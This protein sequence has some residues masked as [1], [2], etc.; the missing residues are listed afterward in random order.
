MQQGLCP[1]WLPRPSLQA[2][3]LTSRAAAVT[4]HEIALLSSPWTSS[5]SE[6]LHILFTHLKVCLW[7]RTQT[8]A[9]THTPLPPLL[10]C[11][12]CCPLPKASYTSMWIREQPGKG[13]PN[14]RDHI[15]LSPRQCSSNTNRARCYFVD[16]PEGILSLS[17]AWEHPQSCWEWGPWNGMF[18]VLVVHLYRNNSACSPGETGQHPQSSPRF[19]RKTLWGKSPPSSH[20]WSSPPATNT[21]K[22]LA[23]FTDLWRCDPD[24]RV[25]FPKSWVSLALFDF[26][27]HSWFSFKM[28]VEVKE[29]FEHQV[30]KL[31][32]IKQPCLAK[33]QP[34]LSFCI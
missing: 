18:L 22:H 29:V 2:P 14:A 23:R 31:F 16:T 24:H 17:L 8:Q 34:L 13:T 32:D 3:P 10:P 7:E 26:V 12:P 9:H 21:T 15:S 25:K 19:L 6:T 4:G 1:P 33:R 11:T 5:A 27:F 30:N 28:M 20:L